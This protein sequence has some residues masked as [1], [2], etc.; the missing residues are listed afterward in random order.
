M[1]A[2][3]LQAGG[4]GDGNVVPIVSRGS[5]KLEFVQQFFDCS[6]YQNATLTATLAQ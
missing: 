3:R 4:S 1:H 6:T 2:F 5:Q